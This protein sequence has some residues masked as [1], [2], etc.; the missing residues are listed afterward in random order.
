MGSKIVNISLPE[1][2]LSLIDK[3]AD[4]ESR[5]RSEFF[6]E[7]AR[8]YIEDFTQKMSSLPSGHKF[9]ISELRA[10]L[11]EEQHGSVR[12][13]EMKARRAIRRMKKG[14]RSSRKKKET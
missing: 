6:R 1:S 14:I 4:E 9:T 11:E 12:G 13:I 7:A 5:S 3:V 2:L 10:M 8:R